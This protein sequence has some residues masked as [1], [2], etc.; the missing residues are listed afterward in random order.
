MERTV[1][2][3]VGEWWVR[4]DAYLD[5]ET[6]PAWLRKVLSVAALAFIFLSFGLLLLVTP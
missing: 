6:W 2:C 1:Y 4:L 3:R 5:E